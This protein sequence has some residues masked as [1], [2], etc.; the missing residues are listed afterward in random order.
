MEGS[1]EEK[2]LLASEVELVGLVVGKK[3]VGYEA[4]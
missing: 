4:L 3:G 1:S 2:L